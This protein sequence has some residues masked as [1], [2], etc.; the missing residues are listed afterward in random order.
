MTEL[1]EKDQEQEANW[2]AASLL[3]PK[4]IFIRF[5]TIIKDIDEL[6]S[7]FEVSNQAAYYRLKNLGMI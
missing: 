7:R 1:D 2:F 6:A 5:W 4:N 3:M